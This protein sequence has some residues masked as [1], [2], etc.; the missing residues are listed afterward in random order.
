MHTVFQQELVIH[1]FWLESLNAEY[2]Y[3]KS[4]DKDEIQEED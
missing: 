4:Q 2:T 1:G 3:I